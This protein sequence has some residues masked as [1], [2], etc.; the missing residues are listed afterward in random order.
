MTRIFREGSV[1]AL[2]D[3][4]QRSIEELKNVIKVIDQQDYAAVIDN[5][6]KDLNCTSIQTIMNHV[7]SAGYLYA[8][9]IRKQFN[10]SC[11]EKKEN[12]ELNTVESACKELDNM[13]AYTVDTLKDKWEFT[14]DD[15]IKNIIITSWGQDYD[16]EQLL[17]HA[18][19]HILR[20]RRQIEK[21]L[22]NNRNFVN[23]QN[24]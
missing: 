6:T 3:E 24:P 23:T 19:V 18:I 14:F 16:F 12:Y 9:Y 11:T 8:N 22:I 1:G 2:A 10:D 20:H 4:Y 21:F 13:L 15:M 5:E 7:V 17:E